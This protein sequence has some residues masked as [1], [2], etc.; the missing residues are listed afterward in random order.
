MK[1]STAKFL[2]KTKQ[3]KCVT[4]DYARLSLYTQDYKKLF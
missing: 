2:K 1:D 4:V 3:G